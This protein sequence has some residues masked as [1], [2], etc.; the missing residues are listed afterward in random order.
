MKLT[1][2]LFFVCLICVTNPRNK[3]FGEYRYIA[4]ENMPL[5]EQLQCAA[6]DGD[7]NAIRELMLKGLDDINAKST[8]LYTTL[9]I[10]PLMQAAERGH[11]DA[12]KALLNNNA[13]PFLED[14]DGLRA[15]ER[16]K[17]A[18]ESLC[19][20]QDHCCC[21]CICLANFCCSYGRDIERLNEVIECLENEERELKKKMKETMKHPTP[22]NVFDEIKEQK[23][24]TKL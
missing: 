1:R 24:G 3:L 5:Q 19:E 7:I 21:G 16:A 20:A 23:K 10:T 18:F 13:N 17:K 15:V 6:R 4:M 2:L 11:I 12:V 22:S 8:N 14:V 9:K